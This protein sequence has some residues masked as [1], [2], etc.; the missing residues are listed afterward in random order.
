MQ[1]INDFRLFVSVV[2]QGGFTASRQGMLPSVRAFLDYASTKIPRWIAG[3]TNDV[4]VPRNQATR[5][6]RC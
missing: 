4:H 2:E 1:D 6:P 3:P 5:M